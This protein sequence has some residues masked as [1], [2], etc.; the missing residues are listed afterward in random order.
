[1]WV[2]GMLIVAHSHGETRVLV[3]WIL[4]SWQQMDPRRGLRCAWVITRE[5]T[6]TMGLFN[7][8]LDHMRCVVCVWVCG[9]GKNK[10]GARTFIA[11]WAG[12]RVVQF[13][14]A[15]LAWRVAFG[16]P[17]GAISR[18][19]RTYEGGALLRVD[20]LVMLPILGETRRA[21][22]ASGGLPSPE[23]I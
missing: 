1:M 8:A 17:F 16:E 19:G 7:V 14:P 21:R 22:E 10:G 4:I 9:R 2:L 18:G 15:G 12:V 3:S 11:P 23:G 20:D 6:G 13:G 5:V